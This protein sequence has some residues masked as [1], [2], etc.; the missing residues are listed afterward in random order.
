LINAGLHSPARSRNPP[1]FAYGFDDDR[2]PQMD[3]T[4][5]PMEGRRGRSEELAIREAKVANRE[6]S[7]EVKEESKERNEEAEDGE[8]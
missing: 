1:R 4:P 5:H 3:A 7:R 8:S 2:G 6:E